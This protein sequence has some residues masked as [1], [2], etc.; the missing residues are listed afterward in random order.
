MDP[1]LLKTI[2]QMGSFGLLAFIVVFYLVRVGPKA[3]SL[4]VE[5]ARAIRNAFL[6]SSDSARRD[7]LGAIEAQRKDFGVELAS[8][9]QLRKETNDRFV[10]I[11]NE[12]TMRLTTLVEKTK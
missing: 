10:N 3:T 6:A 7:F 11:I 2:V 12:L 5:E 4:V 8:E 9:R 1:E